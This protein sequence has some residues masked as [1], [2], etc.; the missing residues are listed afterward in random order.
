M[1]T[2]A[3]ESPSWIL[4]TALATPSQK[5]NPLPKKVQRSHQG[6]QGILCKW[7][8][9]DS[10]DRLNI[11]EIRCPTWRA[12]EP[13]KSTQD[14]QRMKGNIYSQNRTEKVS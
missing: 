4:G 2:V 8:I 1:L 14:T 10:V 7:I 11:L 6:W 9:L 5:E 12:P 13:K 3:G